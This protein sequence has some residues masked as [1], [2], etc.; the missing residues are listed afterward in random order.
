MRT[1]SSSTFT[2]RLIAF[3]REHP[4][5][6]RRRFFQGQP[7]HGLDL[8]DIEWFTTDGVEMAEEDWG[9]GYVRDLGVLLSGDAIPSRDERGEPIRRRHVLSSC[10][11]PAT[12]PLPATLPADRAD[13]WTVVLDTAGE[14][15]FT[16]DGAEVAPGGTVPCRGALDR[17]PAKVGLHVSVQRDAREPAMLEVRSESTPGPPTACS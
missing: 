8:A 11:T 13:R 9:Q 6:R 7:I 3:R 1:R 15:A 5:F 2:T 4:V 16:D 17:G 10:S 12:R 14:R